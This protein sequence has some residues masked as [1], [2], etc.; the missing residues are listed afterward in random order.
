MENNSIF[1]SYAWANKETADEIDND[2]QSIG[3]TFIRDV[4]NIGTFK[5]I[6]E[7][8][9]L[10][11]ENKYVLM[12]ISDS[13][14][15]SE[16]CM[17]EVLE[18]MKELDYKAR[19]LPIILD[20][21]KTIYT[22]KG[23]AN[24]IK[25]W[26][27]KYNDL[28]E[29]IESLEPTNSIQL[30]QNLK[31]IKN[32]CGEIGEFLSILDDIFSVSFDELKKITYKPILDFIGYKDNDVY[33]DL[34]RI[35]MIENEEEQEIELDKNKTK[36]GEKE[37]YYYLNGII[38]SKKNKFKL[39]KYFYEKTLELNPKFTKAH[40]NLATLLM[41]SITDYDMAKE[42]FDIALK[43]NPNIS[44]THNNLANL[45]STGHFKDYTG[46]KEHFNI[47][48]KL[49]F[50]NIEAHLNLAN[51]LHLHFK[52][53]AGAKDQC[54]IVLK[55]NP[56]S[57][58]AHSILATLL[59]TDHFHDYPSAKKHFYI[60]LKLNPNSAESHYNFAILLSD[61]YNDYNGAKRHYKKAL[62]LNPSYIDAHNNLA[63]LLTEHFEEPEESVRHY[64]TALKL[65]SDLKETH[66]KLNDVK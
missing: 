52:D 64:I 41:N 26:Q 56:N 47:S 1:I 7:F 40:Y 34:L 57:D 36:Y 48:L 45:L 66:G 32:I 9:N 2:F 20:D 49:D 59:S 44:E 22:L 28:N 39:S 24:Y 38:A 65:N 50:N 23:K 51:L 43:L 30:T 12:I 15:K 25:Y 62:K 53:Y 58:K 6:K 11:R 17:Y 3:I 16:N 31:I 19:I 18:F 63:I 13:Y 46:A 27:D 61:Y 10:I 14:L 37:D 8:M 60:A 54:D 55:L 42:H 29:I 4:R 35:S 21:A 33:S 5:S